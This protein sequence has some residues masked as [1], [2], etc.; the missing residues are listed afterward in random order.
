MRGK[1]IF[2]YTRVR[3]IK[4]WRRLNRT[5]KTKRV[6]KITEWNPIEMRSKRRSKNIQGDEVLDDLKKLNVKNWTY[7]VEDRKL[8]T[9]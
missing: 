9:N 1:Y 4:W 8:G 6:R 3:R 2:E 5:A 7:L